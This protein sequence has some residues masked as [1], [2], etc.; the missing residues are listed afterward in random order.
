MSSNLRPSVLD[1]F[2]LVTALKLLCKEFEAAHSIGTTCEVDASAPRHIDPAT[3]IALY[4][5]AQEA[6]SNVA[7]HAD[8]SKVSLRV[9][10]QG[11]TLRLMVEDDGK[12]Y[13]AGNRLQAREPGHGLGLISMRER[14]ELLGGTFDAASAPN[15][16]TTISATVPIG[17]ATDDEEDKNSD[18][19]RS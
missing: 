4:R 17:K 19:R 5:I 15:K 9:L 13:D 3:E 18:R 8:A 16:G 14:T 12:G 1:D 7:R 2:G 6:L 11:S 10:H